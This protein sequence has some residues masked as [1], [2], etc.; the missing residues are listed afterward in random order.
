MIWKY[1][2]KDRGST[3]GARPKVDVASRAAAD[4]AEH[5][6]SGKVGGR[7]NERARGGTP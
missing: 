6:R 2:S 5:A 7:V 1:A 4:I 3:G